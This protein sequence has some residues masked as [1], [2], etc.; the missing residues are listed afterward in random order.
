MNCLY[1]YSVNISVGPISNATKLKTC[2]TKR[3]DLY[4]VRWSTVIVEQLWTQN[5]ST[6]KLNKTDL[7]W[8]IFLIF[9]TW[10]CF[11]KPLQGLQNSTTSV[12][13]LHNKI[14]N[15]TSRNYWTCWKKKKKTLLRALCVFCV[16]L[17]NVEPVCPTQEFSTKSF[18]EHTHRS[19]A[20]CDLIQK[21]KFT[22]IVQSWEL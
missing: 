14:K 16:P 18:V 12:A 4:R 9:E 19:T 8:S 13:S 11:K 3:R 22:S 1:D 17:Q 6:W 7:A 20:G 2:A 10:K 5:K 21:W 15:L